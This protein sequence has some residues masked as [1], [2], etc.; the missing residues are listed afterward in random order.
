MR[1]SQAEKGK[2]LSMF[3]SELLKCFSDG[4][5]LHS[6]LLIPLLSVLDCFFHCPS[7]QNL[8]QCNT[9]NMALMDPKIF[10]IKDGLVTGTPQDNP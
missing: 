5:A 10:P 1:E 2:G 9:H 6:L 8:L 7:F 3:W 4:T